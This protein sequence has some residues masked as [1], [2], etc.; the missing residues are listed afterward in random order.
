MSKVITWDATLSDN[1]STSS[2]FCT[3]YIKHVTQLSQTQNQQNKRDDA[4]Q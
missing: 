1:Q 3:L 4:S 2:L